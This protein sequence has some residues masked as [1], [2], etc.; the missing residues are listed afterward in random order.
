MNVLHLS[1]SDI[2][3]GAARASFRL[4]KSFHNS[5]VS[6]WLQVDRKSS[7][8][9]YTIAPPF[10][11]RPYYRLRPHLLRPLL[12]LFS[13]S[14]DHALRSF[15]VL[16]SFRVAS[17]NNSHFDIVHLH[18][19]QAEM[20][21]IF[22]IASITKP[23]VWTF[24]DMWPFCGIYHY[25]TDNRWIDGFTV[26]QQKPSPPKPH[27][28]LDRL[29]WILKKRAWK[30]PVNIIC[31]STWMA[32][33]VRSS[34]LMSDWPVTVIPNAIN[35]HFW[36]PS[37]K[38]QARAE[39]RLP[40]SRTIIAFGAMGGTRDTRKGFDLLEKALCKLLH[41][42]R[43]DQ[44]ALVVFGANDSCISLKQLG[45]HVYPLG[46]IES[47]EQL[48]QIY[49]CVDLL[50]I[51]SRQDNLPNVALEAMSCGTPVAAFA[52]TGLTDIVNHRVN[53]VLA[54][55]FSTDALAEEI[56]WIISDKDRLLSAGRSARDHAVKTWSYQVV[57]SQHQSLYKRITTS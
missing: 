37:S 53:G 15:S 10:I 29:I 48:R 20:L 30:S 28:D 38:T 55:P 24:H 4:H 49:S 43:T 27:I 17:I 47:D 11:L 1:R 32:S 12:P 45:F 16:P 26:P 41:F 3:G 18:W 25:S 2:E 51:P 44:I 13:S 50:V 34:A 36:C 46:S 22:D 5:D 21:S 56:Y 7:A 31:P 54:P 39:L 9:P 57:S 33:C 40:N 8:D 23:L 14:S 42:I 6:S 35:T 19:V 52:S